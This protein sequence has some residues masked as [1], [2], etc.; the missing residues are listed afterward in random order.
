MHSK[1]LFFLSLV[2]VSWYYFAMFPGYSFADGCLPLYGGGITDR[3]FCP[4]PT[5]ENTP[6]KTPVRTKTKPNTISQTK[7]GL[8]IYPAPQ[9]KSTPDTGPEAWPIIGLLPLAGAGFLLRDKA[10][11]KIEAKT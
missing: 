1:Q 10:A 3:Q 2:T 5:P 6:A 8:S 4:T 9:K 11:T 7:G